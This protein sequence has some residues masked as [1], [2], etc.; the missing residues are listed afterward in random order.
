MNQLLV[1]FLAKF[2]EYNK[3]QFIIAGESYAGKYIPSLAKK[4]LDYNAQQLLLPAAQQV[5]LNLTSL[6]IGDP[7]TS[8]VIQR[9]SRHLFTQ[10]NGITDLRHNAQIATLNRRCLESTTK[11]W[12]KGNLD[13]VT[14]DDFMVD[15]SGGTFSYDG[16]IFEADW[17]PI[18]DPIIQYLSNNTLKD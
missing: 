6:L 18:E 14:P 13:C 1:A 10:G 15:V 5:W 9:T 11:N 16:T 8:P 3:R 12:T 2:P 4:I 17:D 7:F